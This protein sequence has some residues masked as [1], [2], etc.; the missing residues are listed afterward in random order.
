MFEIDLWADHFSGQA[1]WRKDKARQHPADT[2]NL[3]A[4]RIFAGL[5]EQV[6]SGHTLP[7]ED[8]AAMNA[9]ENDGDIASAWTL[10]ASDFDRSVG[11]DSF[12]ETPTDYFRR[13]RGLM[14]L[15][16]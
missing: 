6:K 11:F 16:A 1:E 9:I 4:A 5:A 8:I 3:D 7:N 14:R 10:A 13:V 15:A 12:P 2:R